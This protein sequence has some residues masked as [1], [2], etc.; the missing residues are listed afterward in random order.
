MQRHFGPPARA[1]KGNVG[2]YEAGTPEASWLL[3]APFATSRKSRLKAAFL[4]PM[5][6]RQATLG[7]FAW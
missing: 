3:R 2:L 4:L 6:L 5:R 1:A 7:A